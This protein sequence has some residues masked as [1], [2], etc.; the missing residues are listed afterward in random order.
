MAELNEIVFGRIKQLI[1][2]K[3]NLHPFSTY[4]APVPLPPWKYHRLPIARLDQNGWP[5]CVAFCGNHFLGNA[6]IMTP[7]TLEQARTDYRW[8]KANDDIPNEPGTYVRTMLKCLQAQGRISEYVWAQTKD[9]LTQWL[10]LRGPVMVGTE[11]YEG[12]SNPVNGVMHRTGALLGGHAYLIVG[13][14]SIR[15]MFRVLN[16][17]GRT[18]ADKGQAW[19]DED[20]MW[21]LLANNQGEAAACIEMRL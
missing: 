19:I 12:M 5:E 7:R 9:Q 8:C 11:W 15:K 20:D 16:S 3:D 4:L 10:L 18:W 13:Y 21:S 1:D 6:P 2:L 14:S 17:W